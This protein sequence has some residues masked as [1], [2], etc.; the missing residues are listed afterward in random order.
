[1]SMLSKNTLKVYRFYNEKFLKFK[2]TSGIKGNK[3]NCRSYLSGLNVSKNT[4]QVIKSALE[5][6]YGTIKYILATD[7]YQSKG[8][9]NILTKEQV[10]IMFNNTENNKHKMIISLTYLCGI[11]PSEIIN[12]QF[13]DLDFRRDTI[14]IIKSKYF[15]GARV[16]HIDPILKVL[17]HEYITKYIT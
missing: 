3:A 11:R 7:I 14:H 2:F 1:M 16:I 6:Y 8:E 10:Q 17:L 9:I 15:D 12:I 5:Y 4:F 13:N